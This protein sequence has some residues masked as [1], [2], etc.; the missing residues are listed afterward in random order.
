[1]LY[2]RINYEVINFKKTKNKKY[3]EKSYNF[4]KQILVL[5]FQIIK[6]GFLFYSINFYFFLV[7][8]KIKIKKE[9]EMSLLNTY[10]ETIL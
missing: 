6:L 3:L 1:M 4:E 7:Q 2:N 8:E 5:E 10:T 9:R